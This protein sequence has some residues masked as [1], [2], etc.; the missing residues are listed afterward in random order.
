M[1]FKHFETESGK[2]IKTAQFNGYELS[3]KLDGITF[4][5]DIQDDGTTKVYVGSEDQELFDEFNTTMWLKKAQEVIDHNPNMVLEDPTSGEDCWAVTDEVTTLPQ[6]TGHV[7][8]TSTIDEILN[9]KENLDNLDKISKTL[10]KEL[11]ETEEKDEVKE[12]VIG[13]FKPKRKFLNFITGLK[14]NI[15]LLNN[16]AFIKGEKL[17][18]ML[19]DV[20]FKVTI[21]DEGTINFEEVGTNQSTPQMLKNFIDDIDSLDVTGYTR[22][23]VVSGLEFYDD[24]NKVCY[25]EV[26]HKKPIETLFSLFEEELPKMSETGMSLLEALFSSESDEELARE[27]EGESDEEINL[28][29]NDAEIVVQNVLDSPQPNT[30]LKKAAQRYMEENFNRLNEEKIFELKSRIER[31]EQEVYK[32]QHEIKQ[33]ERKLDTT[34]DNLRVLNTRLTSLQPKDDSVGYDFFVS[35]ENKTGIE[36]DENLVSV[37]EKIAPILK[38]NTPVVI[39]MLTKGYYTI[40]VQKQGPEEDKNK[41]DKEIYQ[42]IQKIDVMGKVT[43]IGTCEFEYRGDMTWHQLVDKMIRMGFDQNPDFDKEC[44]SNSYETKEEEKAE[45]NDMKSDIMKMAESLEKSGVKGIVDLADN[46]IKSIEENTETKFKELA[47]FDTPTDIVIFGNYDSDEYTSIADFMITDDESTF[48]LYVNGV[49]KSTLSSSGFGCIMPL[50]DYKKLYSKRGKEMAE[51]A[52]VDGY[53][54]SGFVGKI[55]I[56]AKLEDGSFSTDFD[57]TD[58][59]QHQLD[60]QGSWCDVIV[61]ITGNPQIFKLNDDL[62]VPTAVLR[63]VNIDKIIK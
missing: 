55:E 34:K 28:S 20:V 60:Y 52:I 22:K 5:V 8:K 7:I 15:R 23:F 17:S 25:L 3:E 4:K 32:I 26:E 16:Y 13:Q 56:G 39:D 29:E 51:F 42:K 21:C 63:D 61:N 49:E 12:P 24:E 40:K 53:V 38:L 54:I 37:V 31:T 35:S 58:Y 59:I 1:K 19:E 10:E 6:K 9:S 2:T 44:G 30:D 27:L 47:T 57:I 43:M 11:G 50:D 45:T 46:S 41:L 18:G 48:D 36:P 62:S 14:G 33:S